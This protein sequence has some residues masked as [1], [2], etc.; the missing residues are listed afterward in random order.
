ML[1][2]HVVSE[3]TVCREKPAR[4]QRARGVRTYVGGN[5]ELSVMKFSFLKETSPLLL[6]LSVL[7]ETPPPLLGMSE[8]RSCVKVEVA[9]LGC[10]S[11]IVCVQYRLCGH[12]TTSN[13]VPPSSG[14]V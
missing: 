5:E 13:F 14:V 4:F 9:V 3:P 10:P 2:V 6:N 8:L 7:L 1:I 12:K 11:L